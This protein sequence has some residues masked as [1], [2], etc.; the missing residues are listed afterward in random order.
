VPRTFQTSTIYY[1]VHSGFSL[2]MNAACGEPAC[3]DGQKAPNW[4]F[5]GSNL[6]FP[7]LTLKF[8]RMAGRVLQ[9]LSS[10]SRGDHWDLFPGSPGVLRDTVA[11]SPINLVV[12]H[13]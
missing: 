11:R 12:M 3:N 8:L 1:I 10:V 7:V 2:A 4:D 13:V 5:R 9:V 6:C